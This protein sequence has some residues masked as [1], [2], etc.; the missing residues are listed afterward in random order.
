MNKQRPFFLNLL[1]IR[2]PIGGV[3]S[4]LHRASGALLALSVPLLLYW[5]MLSLRSAEDFQT[6]AA[7]FSGGFGTL[8]ML[9]CVWALAHH[10]L[11][12]MRHLGFDIGWGEARSTSR[13]TAWLS[14]G[15]AV[16]V[17]ALVAFWRF[18]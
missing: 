16:A 10:F 17:T 8:I 9:A 7:W 4:I 2:L 6:L 15:I 13:L 11:A 12:G 18:A 1:A 3:T 5:L 14:I